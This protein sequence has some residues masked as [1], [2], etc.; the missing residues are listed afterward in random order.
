MFKILFLVIQLVPNAAQAFI[1]KETYADAAACEAALPIRVA[2]VQTVFN[3]SNG[4]DSYLID[5]QCVSVEKLS[6][7]G[8]PA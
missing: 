8:N 6:R 2:T 5:G 7:M 1:S 4:P 3:V